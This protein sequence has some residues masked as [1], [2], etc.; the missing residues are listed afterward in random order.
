MSAETQ[1]LLK[2]RTYLTQSQH[3]SWSRQQILDSEIFQEISMDT[4][5]AFQQISGHYDRQLQI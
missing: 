2:H 1:H 5:G 3:T 4:S